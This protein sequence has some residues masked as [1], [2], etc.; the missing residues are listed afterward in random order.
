MGALL[1]DYDVL[2]VVLHFDVLWNLSKLH[3]ST[4]KSAT[5]SSVPLSDCRSKWQGS[6]GHWSEGQRQVRKRQTSPAAPSLHTQG[7]PNSCCLWLNGAHRSFPS[8][9]SHGASGDRNCFPHPKSWGI[10]L[11]A[12]KEGR[13]RRGH[14]GWALWPQV[15]PSQGQVA[16]SAR[17]HSAFGHGK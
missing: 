12:S 8:Q 14:G 10:K 9:L 13:G 15:A 7:T 1:T 4:L 16:G 2:A 17:D 6:G 5:A 11:Q 3:F